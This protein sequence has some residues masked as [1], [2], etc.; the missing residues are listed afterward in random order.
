[1]CFTFR[2]SVKSVLSEYGILFPEELQTELDST[3]LIS[4]RILESNKAEKIDT[5][6]YRAKEAC[7]LATLETLACHLKNFLSPLHDSVDVL[8]F[9]SL[10]KS[11]ILKKCIEHFKMK[12]E[13][14]DSPGVRM[15]KLNNAVQ[16]AKT[17]VELLVEDPENLLSLN[18]VTDVFLPE[19]LNVLDLSNE[20]IELS[21][22]YKLKCGELLHVNISET[23][24]TFLELYYVCN[25][26]KSLKAVCSGF[27]L[28]NCLEDPVMIRLLNISIMVAEGNQIILKDAK[29]EVDFIKNS[30]GITEETLIDHPLFILFLHLKNGCPLYDFASERGYGT[31]VGMDTFMQEHHLVTTNL[32][33]EEFYEDVLA[34]LIAAMELIF[35]FFDRASTLVELWTNIT[36]I[37]NVKAAT[38]QMLTVNENIEAVRDWFSQANVSFN[39]CSIAL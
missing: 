35:P 37:G 21:Q 29:S 12:F 30:F 26:S 39:V 14:T 19:D 36:K 25:C 17:F 11:Q 1:M 15:D 27:G 10:H 20:N 4:S 31:V 22:F 2:K 34:K 32:L 33:F 13:E 18:A 9:L 5:V 24:T 7:T 28:N 16:K 3:L 8:V 6:T 38:S 23:L